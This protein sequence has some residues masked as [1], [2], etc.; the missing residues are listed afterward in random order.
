[1]PA[2]KTQRAAV[3]A[4]AAA[5]GMAGPVAVLAT[6]TNRAY[7]RRLSILLERRDFATVLDLRNER[8][9]WLRPASSTSGETASP[10]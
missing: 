10:M 3:G 7:A 6:A 1:M 9:R 8:L 4:F 2:C 5:M